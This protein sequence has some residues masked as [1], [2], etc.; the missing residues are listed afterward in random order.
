[1]KRRRHHRHTGPGQ[2]EAIYV[3]G[4]DA[5]LQREK[6]SVSFADRGRM[7]ALMRV[8]TGDILSVVRQGEKRLEVPTATIGIRGTGCYIEA[9]RSRSYFCLCYGVAEVAPVAGPDARSG[10]SDEA[11]TT[12]SDPQTTRRCR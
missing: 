8:I 12:R 1:M 5:Y 2:R 9:S 10:A 3:I 7:P 6:S 4:Q 11:T